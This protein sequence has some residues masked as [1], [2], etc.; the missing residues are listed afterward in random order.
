MKKVIHFI[1]V[2]LV[3]AMAFGFGGCKHKHDFVDID[4]KEPTCVEDGYRK[5]RCNGCGEE[6]EETLYA[7]GH[8]YNMYNVCIRCDYELD[9]TLGLGYEETEDGNGYY[10]SVGSV[11]L[12]NIVIPAYHDAKRVVGVRE[13]GFFSPIAENA[14]PTRSANI[15][16]MEL[17]DGLQKIG[18]RGFY[19][20]VNL[21]TLIL[22][23]GGLK[24]IGDQAFGMCTSLEDVRNVSAGVESIGS[25][26]FY[27]CSSLRSLPAFPALRTVGEYAFADCTALE[28]AYFGGNV[29]SVATGAFMG[30]SRLR[31]VSLGN[32]ASIPGNAFTNC[33][34]LEEVIVSSALKEISSSA[35]Y[36]CKALKTI[37]F[38]G[39]VE[40]WKAVKK[41]NDWF[42][43]SLEPGDFVDFYVNCTD[44]VLDHN[45]VLMSQN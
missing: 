38:G 37:R 39:T 11:S 28:S 26:A 9:Y 14:T 43:T 10:V 22:P 2:A 30:C 20:C 12:T 19:G 36:E 21:K 33:T 23:R 13:E 1:S 32:A 29:E 34:A 6:V 7:L 35:F 42:L 8:D 44:G 16:S 45:G 3:A 40:E 5:S 41:A 17:P 27:A 24:E 15:V 4:Y 18:T 25:N 31:F